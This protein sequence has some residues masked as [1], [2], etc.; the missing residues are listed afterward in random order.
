MPNVI[1]SNRSVCRSGIFKCILIFI[2]S[3]ASTMLY[4]L[5]LPLHSNKDGHQHHEKES[6]DQPPRKKR[7]YDNEENEDN[8]SQKN[9]GKKDK[10]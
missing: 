5:F 8:E 9:V 10:E 3:V 7:K 4:E 1:H 6:T 2:S